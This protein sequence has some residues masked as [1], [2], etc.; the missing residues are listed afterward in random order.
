MTSYITIF[1]FGN[2][3]SRS[4]VVEVSVVRRGPLFEEP[5]NKLSW[6]QRILNFSSFLLINLSALRMYYCLF[7]LR[8]TK[9]S[10]KPGPAPATR[11]FQ[12][13][14]GT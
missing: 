10:G 7:L 1:L 12:V 2:P 5:N 11:H 14:G 13:K 6:G 8:R 3:L 9:C 4:R